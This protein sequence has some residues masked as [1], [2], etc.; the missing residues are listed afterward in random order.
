MLENVSKK[1][2]FRRNFELIEQNLSKIDSEPNFE[3]FHFKQEGQK[4]ANSD[5]N[6]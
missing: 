6:D 5:D 3:E 4:A 2:V 1:F